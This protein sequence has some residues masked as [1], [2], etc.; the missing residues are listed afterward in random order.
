[1][2]DLFDFLHAALPWIAIGLLLAVFFARHAG[3]KKKEGKNDDYG[4][5]GMC[6]GMCMGSALGASGVVDIGL[7]MSLGMLIG[8]VIGA[9]FLKEEK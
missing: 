9:F 3:K 5:E 1:M 7:G 4:T 6:L 8:L 2:N